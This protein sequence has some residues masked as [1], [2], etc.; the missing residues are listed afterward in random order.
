MFFLGIDLGS[1]SIKLSV[2][3]PEKGTT[4]GA[5][6]VPDFEMPIIAQQFGWAEQDPESWWQYVKDGIKQLGAK[7][8]IDLKKIAGIGIA[9]QMHGLVLTDENLNP[10]RSSI[11]W[12]D[13]RAAIIGDEI[14]AQI[15]AENCQKQILGSP[16]NFT[17]S[18]LKWVKE[19]Q[20]EIFAKAK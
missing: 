16:G 13:S 8:N 10:V 19:N 2:F 14:Y 15:G 3:D 11:I 18:K 6:S 7:S 20:P 12:C 9:Y 17:A 5:V 1:S 4:I